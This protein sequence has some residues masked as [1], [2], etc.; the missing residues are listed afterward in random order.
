MEFKWEEIMV[1]DDRQHYAYRGNQ[2]KST[3]ELMDWHAGTEALEVLEPDLPIVDCHHHLF[4]TASDRLYYRMDDLQHDLDSGHNLI[5]TVYVE[6]YESGWRTEGPAAL[7]PVG[8][9]EMIVDA[10]AKPG[11]ASC[12]IA[13]AIVGHADLT[14]GASVADVLE[15]EKIASQGR[16]SGIRYRVA[17][18]GGT[19]ARV[20]KSQPPPHLLADPTFRHG[21]AAV[22]AAGL[23]FDTWIYHTQIDELIGLADACPEATIVICHVATP[24][25]VGEY[26]RRAGETFNDWRAGIV[27][28]A[29]R[30]KV[31]MKLGGLGMPV[32]GFAFDDAPR[33][34]NAHQLVKAWAPYLET[35][36]A[37][38]GTKRC[39]FESNFPVDK[40]SCSYVELWNAYKLF[41]K[42][43]S[44]DERADLF[45]RAACTTYDLPGL[46]A[47]G[48]AAMGV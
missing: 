7:R 45:Y 38:F 5:G 10:T 12:K 11:R 6:A 1:A 32:F 25:G 4:G 21:V 28:L 17:S 37:A 22:A 3:Q 9:I 14:L 40:Q 16:L 31:R 39:M 46:Q 35:C 42:G 23:C 26:R 8:E 48:D 20:I 47:V 13:A 33:P 30:Q 36:F 2:P 29:K 19:I 24:I 34:A 41:S 27:E 18:D 44:A 15:A 43:F